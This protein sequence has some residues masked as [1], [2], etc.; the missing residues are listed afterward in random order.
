VTQLIFKCPYQKFVG[1]ATRKIDG[2]L[3]HQGFALV[4]SVPEKDDT[5]FDRKVFEVLTETG[6]L[7]H[8]SLYAVNDIVAV[9]VLGE[10][11]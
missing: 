2:T 7:K 6:L 11:A 1:I 9:A 3:D 4:N 8:V 5:L 10:P